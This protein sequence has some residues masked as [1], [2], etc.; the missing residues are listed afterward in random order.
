[1]MALMAFDHERLDVYQVALEFFDLADEIVE[2][3]R[4]RLQRS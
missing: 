1:M 3:L 4:K 2:Q